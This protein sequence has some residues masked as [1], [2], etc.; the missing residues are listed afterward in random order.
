MKVKERININWGCIDLYRWF[1][2]GE[3]TRMEIIK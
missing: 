2:S 3:G 1:A